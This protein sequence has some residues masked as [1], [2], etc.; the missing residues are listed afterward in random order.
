MKGKGKARC[1][2]IGAGRGPRPYSRWLA[3][4]SRWAEEGGAGSNVGCTRYCGRRTSTTAH[5]ASATASLPLELAVSTRCCRWRI[6]WRPTA[7]PRKQPPVPA[8]QTTSFGDSG[9]SERSGRRSSS[10]CSSGNPRLGAGDPLLPVGGC[11]DWLD[12]QAPKE[13]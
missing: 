2:A 4:S 7:L 10:S 1:A 9:R 6:P 8:E 3:P 11:V 5:A 12:G 13:R